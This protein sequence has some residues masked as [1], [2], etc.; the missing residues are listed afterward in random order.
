MKSSK[1]HQSTS[2]INP[3]FEVLEFTYGKA[4]NISSFKESAFNYCSRQVGPSRRRSYFALPV[5]SD[6]HL[7]ML[8]QKKRIHPEI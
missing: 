5:S 1:S 2:A 4:S 6:L 3:L 7:Q 8:S